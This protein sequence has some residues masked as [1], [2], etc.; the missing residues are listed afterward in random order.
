MYD[1][2]NELVLLNQSIERLKFEKVRPQSLHG[3][4]LQVFEMFSILKD[5]H[6]VYLCKLS[7][8]TEQD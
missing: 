7:V 2:F 5:L 6:I 1:Y 8:Q 4:Q 3:T